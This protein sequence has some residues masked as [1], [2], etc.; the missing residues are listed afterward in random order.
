MQ[1]E[2]LRLAKDFVGVGNKMFY[3]NSWFLTIENIFLCKHKFRYLISTFCSSVRPS[4]R[5]AIIINRKIVDLTT[6]HSQ[7]N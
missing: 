3:I 4:Y 2:H 1:K 6:G 5:F 7:N